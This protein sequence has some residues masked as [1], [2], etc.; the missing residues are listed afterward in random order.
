MSL[1]FD[2]GQLIA[3]VDELFKLTDDFYVRAR[4][5]ATK[6]YISHEANRESTSRIFCEWIDANRELIACHDERMFLVLQDTSSGIAEII[7]EIKTIWV[8]LPQ[9][10]KDVIWAWM[11]HFVAS[12]SATANLSQ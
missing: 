12:C 3:F 11:E 1:T 6:L 2:L 7:N 8:T 10:E 5:F 9:C 4:I